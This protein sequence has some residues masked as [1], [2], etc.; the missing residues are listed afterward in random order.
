MNTNAICNMLCGAGFGL[1]V[2]SVLGCMG[3][4]CETRV[5]EDWLTS[6][7]YGAYVWSNGQDG[8][9]FELFGFTGDFFADVS[10]EDQEMSMT[11]TDDGAEMVM[12]FAIGEVT[13]FE[14]EY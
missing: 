10:L 5:T 3:S 7:A 2:Q 11:W 6:G 9:L 4:D 13:T 1:A 8:S 12:I 14:T